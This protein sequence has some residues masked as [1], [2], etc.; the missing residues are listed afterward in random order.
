M[1]L[2]Y[3][4]LEARSRESVRTGGVER[5]QTPELGW[6]LAVGVTMCG[7][8]H[9]TRHIKKT[10]SF[11]LRV[12]ISPAPRAQPPIAQRLSAP[13]VDYGWMSGWPALIRRSPPS[14]EY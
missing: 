13:R 6:A 8:G 5:R 1:R 4:M 11:N 10:L 14:G 3:A 12:Y 9:A 2:T 7:E